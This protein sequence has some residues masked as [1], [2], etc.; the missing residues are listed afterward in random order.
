MRPEPEAFHGTIQLLSQSA[1]KIVAIHNFR[2]VSENA[3]V[4]QRERVPLLWPLSS[5][6]G[7]QQGG[8]GCIFAT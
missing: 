6:K 1:A 3:F 5:P 2:G 7:C 8:A 4:Y